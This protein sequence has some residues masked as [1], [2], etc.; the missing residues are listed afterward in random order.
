M[1]SGTQDFSAF[2]SCH[3][4]CISDMSLRDGRKATADLITTQCKGKK[5]RRGK[6]T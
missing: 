3:S 4:W 2:P 5:G 6:E 1:S